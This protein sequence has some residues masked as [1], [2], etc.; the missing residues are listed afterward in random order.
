MGSKLSTWKWKNS[1][2]ISMSLLTDDAVND[3]TSQLDDFSNKQFNILQQ[4]DTIARKQNTIAKQQNNIAKQQDIIIKHQKNHLQKIKKLEKTLEDSVKEF[5]SKI[6]LIENQK[7]LYKILNSI[8]DNS[9]EFYCNRHQS[10]NSISW[11]PDNV[12]KNIYLNCLTFLK[13]IVKQD[14]NLLESSIYDNNEIFYSIKDSRTGIIWNDN[15][16]TKST[17]NTVTIENKQ[18]NSN[19]HN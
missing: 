13:A 5:N 11:L 16:D 15:N 19:D 9:I 3:I 2:S 17:Q 10:D 18:D 8:H 6:K 12:E 7:S 4:Q 14:E 1:N